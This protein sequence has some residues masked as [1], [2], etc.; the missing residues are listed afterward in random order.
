[1]PTIGIIDDREDIREILTENVRLYLKQDWDVV[2]VPPLPEVDEY[3]S[4]ISQNDIVAIII[5][6]KLDEKIAASSEA[7]KYLG[8]DLVD[9]IRERILELP[10]FVITSFANEPDLVE[11]FKYVEDII[12]RKDYYSRPS[13]YIERITRAAQ[14][15]LQ[16]YESE[17]AALASFS[18]KIASG[19][20]VTD[21]EIRQAKA[22]KTKIESAYPIGEITGRNAWLNHMEILIDQLESLKT[23]IEERLGGK[24]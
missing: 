12:D 17:L 24:N 9:Y 7:V 14:R 11:R 10:I 5:D 13:D 18:E 15:Y 19:E 4:W 22:I 1:M 23:Q 2:G 6:E 3:P 16:T 8:H 21:D 20:D